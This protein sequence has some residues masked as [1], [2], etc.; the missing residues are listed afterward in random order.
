MFL[1]SD[2]LTY[3][4]KDWKSHKIGRIN[5]HYQTGY[6]LNEEKANRLMQQLEI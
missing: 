5:Y 4:T 1:L 3:T 2:Y 6:I